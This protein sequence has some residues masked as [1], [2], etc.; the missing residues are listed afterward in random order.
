VGGSGGQLTMP[1]FP[2]EPGEIIRLCVVIAQDDVATVYDLLYL[3]EGDAISLRTEG[4]VT[5]KTMAGLVSKSAKS[6]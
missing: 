2:I 3:G 6:W 4:Y 5:L 1:N